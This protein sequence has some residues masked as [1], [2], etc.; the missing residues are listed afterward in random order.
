MGVVIALTAVFLPM[1]RRT[2]DYPTALPP[3]TYDA[4]AVMREHARS[5]SLPTPN[6]APQVIAR[7]RALNDA[8]AERRE[9][10]FP[11]AQTAFTSDY[12]VASGHRPEAERAL[13]GR[14]RGEFFAALHD[15]RAPL[16]RIAARHRLAGPRATRDATRAVLVAWFDLRWERLA[17]PTPEH[18]E[19]EPMAVTLLRIP[20]PEQRAFAAWGLAARCPVLL[21]VEGRPLRADDARR[22]ATLRRELLDVASGVDRA[23]PRDEATAAVDMMLGTGL[24]RLTDPSRAEA[25]EPTVV[26]DTERVRARD[27]ATA[28]FQHAAERYAAMERRGHDARVERYLRAALSE[29]GTTSP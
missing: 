23:Y 2:P 14:A 8:M 13:R 1:A 21:G 25:S 12:G 10:D 6:A 4:D 7:W 28:A 5:R 16:T 11:L 27:E 20:R 15:P 24:L 9:A 22:C 29:L 26:D 19:V 18:G 3:L 17:L